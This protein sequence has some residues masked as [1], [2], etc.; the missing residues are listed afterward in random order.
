MEPSVTEHCA[1]ECG[2]ND[3]CRA[4]YASEHSLHTSE[5]KI[6]PRHS[7]VRLYKRDAPPT[8]C[9]FVASVYDVWSRGVSW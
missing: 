7:Y 8:L 1:A 5:V 4:Y 3:K 2:K 9:S 6:T